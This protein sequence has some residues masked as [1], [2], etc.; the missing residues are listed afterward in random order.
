MKLTRTRARLPL[1][2]EIILEKAYLNPEYN[3]AYR[4]S[5]AFDKNITLWVCD[6]GRMVFRR[7]ATCHNSSESYDRTP[8]L[9]RFLS[10]R[11]SGARGGALRRRAHRIPGPYPVLSGVGRTALRCGDDRR[12]GGGRSGGRGGARRA[13]VGGAAGGGRSGGGPWLVAAP[14]R[15]GFAPR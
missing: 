2:W 4:R 8:L 9:H 6:R 10:A 3:I 1:G 13:P 5:P 14:R 7:P 12:R 11:V 15:P